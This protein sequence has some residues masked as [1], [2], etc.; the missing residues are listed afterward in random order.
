MWIAIFANAKWVN[1]GNVEFIG[2][3]LKKCALSFEEKLFGTKS[4]V[5]LKRFFT[6]I[7]VSILL[8]KY[9]TVKEFCVS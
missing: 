9:S 2:V 4:K 7:C 5:L 3:S 6:K 1:F 8:E